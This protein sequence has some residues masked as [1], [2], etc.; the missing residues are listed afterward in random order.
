MIKNKTAS[1][2]YVKTMVLITKDEYNE[3]KQN[4]QKLAGWLL[5]ESIE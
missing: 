2:A 4:Q 5:L 3:L 1:E